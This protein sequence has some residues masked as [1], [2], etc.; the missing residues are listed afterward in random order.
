MF[1]IH[2][3][4]QE[5]LYKFFNYIYDW[6][7]QPTLF[8][9]SFYINSIKARD[10][11]EGMERAI[12]MKGPWTLALPSPRP[13]LAISHD[14]DNTDEDSRVTRPLRQTAAQIMDN[15]TVADGVLITR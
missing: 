3:L 8:T 15:S 2:F 9:N 4:I 14:Q 5:I 12:N 7:N 10:R 1:V 13:Q 11:D 6:Q